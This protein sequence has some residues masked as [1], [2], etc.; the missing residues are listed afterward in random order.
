M[1]LPDNLVGEWGESAIIGRY[2]FRPNKEGGQSFGNQVTVIR[3]EASQVKAV[4]QIDCDAPKLVH[5]I[6]KADSDGFLVGAVCSSIEGIITPGFM[7]Y[8]LPVKSFESGEA[9]TW[10]SV[11]DSDDGARPSLSAWATEVARIERMAI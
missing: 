5:L 2:Q 1:T 11:A 10:G 3:L 6:K 7:Q 8:S 9:Q 4:F